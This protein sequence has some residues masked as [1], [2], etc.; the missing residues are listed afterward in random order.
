[1]ATL[2]SVQTCRWG[3]PTLF[4]GWPLWY[5]ASQHEWSCVRGDA[6][7]VLVDPV[8]CRTCPH[9]SP[10]ERQ[11][12]PALPV[13]ACDECLY[14]RALVPGARAGDGAPTS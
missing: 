1:M 4:L 5:E 6:V 8:M 10:A 3:T 9:W 7:R 13:R 12:E 11:M 14:R 2:H